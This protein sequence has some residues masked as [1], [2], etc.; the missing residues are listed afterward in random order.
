MPQPLR[1][2]EGRDVYGL[3][4]LVGN[5]AIKVRQG[6]RMLRNAVAVIRLC[7]ALGIPGYLENPQSSL[8]WRTAGMRKLIKLGC[9]RLV[10]THMC[11]HG[12]QWRKATSF[13]FWNFKHEVIL[14]VCHMKKGRCSASG[15]RHLLSGLS[16]S[17]F[18]T[19]Q[20]QIYPRTLAN[21]LAQLV[22]DSGGP[23]TRPRTF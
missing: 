21:L 1:G 6:N 13:L 18:T 8:I 23:P 15:K 12:A 5:D 2:V 3:P 4:G 20:A 7:L 22:L 16:G 17:T 14:P 9:V 19:Q 11:Q 10:T